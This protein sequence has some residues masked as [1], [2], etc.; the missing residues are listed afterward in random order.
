MAIPDSWIESQSPLPGGGTFTR[1]RPGPVIHD[2]DEPTVHPGRGRRLIRTSD[3]MTLALNSEQAR[4]F[5]RPDK[6]T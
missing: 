3:G 4:Q 2:A 1:L 6:G 5:G